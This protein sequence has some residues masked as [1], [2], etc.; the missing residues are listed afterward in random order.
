MNI[1]LVPPT[2]TKSMPQIGPSPLSRN[3]LLPPL[4][5]LTCYAHSSYGTNSY[6]RL[7]SHS[8]SY[9]SLDKILP[10]QPTRNFMGQSIST[11][12][13]LPHLGPKPSSM[14]TQQTKHLGHHTPPTV[15]TMAQG[16]TTTNASCSTS[17]QHGNSNSQ[18]HGN[19]IL[20][21]ANFWSHWSRTNP[22]LLPPTS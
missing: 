11:R 3:T 21:T 13:L 2:T 19:Y 5:L 18:T 7:N 17:L 6:P 8:T 10:F 22:S 20:H 1:Q 14:T 15:Y 12:H 9:G 16:L 4:P